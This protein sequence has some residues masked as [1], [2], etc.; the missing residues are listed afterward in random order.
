M[1]SNKIMKQVT[2]IFNIF[3]VLFYLGVGIYLA[4]FFRNPAWNSAILGLTGGFFI[5]YGLYRAYKAYVSIVDLFFRSGED[6]D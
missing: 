4:F 1:D 3:M 5:L 6:E 2:A